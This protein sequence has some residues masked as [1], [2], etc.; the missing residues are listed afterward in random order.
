MAIKQATVDALTPKIFVAFA[1][2]SRSTYAA[3]AALDQDYSTAAVRRGS[4]IDSP[5]DMAGDPDEVEDVTTGLT[6]QGN[7][8]S[9]DYGYHQMKLDKYKRVRFKLTHREAHELL[10]GIMPSAVRTKADS[11]GRFLNREVCRLYKQIPYHVKSATPFDGDDL[12]D[13]VL[14]DE[15]AATQEMPMEQRRLILA[16]AAYARAR[17]NARLKDADKTGMPPGMNDH[18]YFQ[19]RGY[20]FFLDQQCEKH[21]KGT[22]T[23]NTF[24]VNGAVAVGDKNITIDAITGT[25]ADGDILLRASDDAVIGAVKGAVAAQDT[26]VELYHGALVAVADDADIEIADTT[27]RQNLLTT[28]GGLKIAVRTIQS[29]VANPNE[30]IERDPVT[31]MPVVMS[32][33]QGDDEVLWTFK[34]LFGLDIVQP[35]RTMRIVSTN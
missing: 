21:T 5:I 18:A 31:G 12:A 22:K 34:I 13:V 6:P 19:S 32:V 9:P 23:G 29:P 1:E 8:S 26:A 14:I 4:V 35:W 2:A 25:I 27:G 17:S 33:W 24:Q 3:L 16:Q 7:P 20:S 15:Q 30:H 28:P 11:L 10:E